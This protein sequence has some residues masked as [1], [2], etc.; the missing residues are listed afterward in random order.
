MAPVSHSEIEAQARVDI[1][2]LLRGRVW[3]AILQV[4]GDTA[5]AYA[6]IDKTAEGEYD[7]QVRSHGACPTSP[8]ACGFPLSKAFA[9][10]PCG[11][12][13]PLAVSRTTAQ[14]DVDI[15]RC[16]QYHPLMASPEGHHKL[17]S[18]LKAW[19]AVNDKLVYWQGA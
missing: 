19:V 15:P 16:H 1:P 5:A 14:I 17:R 2:P 13:T 6:A 9:H 4:E 12:W 7:R 18:L 3:S 8:A 11:L 10:V